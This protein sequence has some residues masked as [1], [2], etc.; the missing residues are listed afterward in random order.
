M[1]Q[2]YNYYYNTSPLIVH[3]PLMD[4]EGAWPLWHQIITDPLPNKCVKPEDLTI[5]T[6]NNSEY[7]S[8]LEKQL[9]SLNISFICLGKGIQWTSNRLKPLTLLENKDKLNTKYVLGLDAFDVVIVDT[10]QNI[11]SKFKDTKSKLL[12]N[13]TATVYPDVKEHQI[14]EEKL[15][16]GPFRYF[17]SGMF[18]GETDYLISVLNSIDYKEK[19]HVKSDQYLIRGLYHKFYPDIQIDWSCKI[20]QIMFMKEAN[21]EDYVRVTY[22]Y[23]VM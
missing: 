11:I 22:K 5:V 18:I 10:L 15:C 17:N 6:W 23:K 16:Q 12:Y 2:L 14:I 19:L 21:L 1:C 8:L 4:I 7:E 20:F 3:N 13:A 9:K